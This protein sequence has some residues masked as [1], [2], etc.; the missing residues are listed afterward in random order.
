MLHHRFTLQWLLDTLFG[1]AW[2]SL[3][4]SDISDASLSL[5]LCAEVELESAAD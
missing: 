5:G 3:G 1:E 4:L 2:L